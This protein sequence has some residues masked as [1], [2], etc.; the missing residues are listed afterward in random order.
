MSASSAT[1]QGYLVVW[2]LHALSAV[3]IGL[4]LNGIVPE[5]RDTESSHSTIVIALLHM[6]TLAS[7]IAGM[8]YTQRAM[9][10]TNICVDASAFTFIY[11]L[12]TSQH[13]TI[14]PRMSILLDALSYSSP[15]QKEAEQ[16]HA[17]LI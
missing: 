4:V 17:V 14:G 5:Y 15:E 8:R 6:C 16:F 1:I 11:L 13:R 7:I 12:M 2:I 3:I 9:E 10:I